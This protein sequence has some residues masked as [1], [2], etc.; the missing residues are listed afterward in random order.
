MEERKRELLFA[1]IRPRLRALGLES[2]EAYLE[3]LNGH[4]EETQEFVNMVTTNETL[5]FRTPLIW[6]YFRNEYLPQ[7]YAQN[8][9]NTLRIWSAA[10]S[11]GEES[12]SIAMTCEE[13]KLTKPAFRY[14]ISGS[15]IDTNVLEKARSGI[16]KEKSAEEFKKKHPEFFEKYFKSLPSGECKASD[17]LIQRMDFSIHN[18]HTRPSKIGHYDIVFL[19]N[20]LIYFTDV[21]Q[22]LVLRNIYQAVKPGGQLIVG[23]SESLARLKTE[24]HFHKPLIYKKG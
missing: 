19:R 6:D 17:V 15:D 7:W 23:E 1:R 22:E 20:V 8:P 13:F 10:S 9:D 18:L 3:Y 21:D 12:Y 24:F 11:S 4:S 16:F 2:P 14:Q 5:F